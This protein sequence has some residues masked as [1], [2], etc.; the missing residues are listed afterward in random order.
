MTALKVDVAP[1]GDEAARRAAE[2]LCETVLRSDSVGAVCLAGGE[3]PRRMYAYLAD[4]PIRSRFPWTR[5]H[6][7]LGDER[8]V[9]LD[10][11]RSNFRMIREALLSRAPIAEALIH[12]VPTENVDPERSASLYQSELA[13]LYGSDRLRPDKPLFDFVVLGLGPDG[14]TASLFPGRPEQDEKTRWVLPVPGGV[15]EPRITLTPP[16]LRS[17]R[18]VSFLVVG[19]GKRA[20]FAKLRARDGSIPAAR[21]DSSG[22]LCA[23]VDSAAAG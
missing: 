15:L 2:R 10:D 4:E 14:H 1:T 12:P 22:E 9:P 8:F 3:T 21:I 6:W 7:F 16:A 13:A 11:E 17:A 5:V 20:A 23:F 19:D 18:V